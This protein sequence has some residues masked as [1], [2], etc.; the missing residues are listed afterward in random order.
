MLHPCICGETNCR[1]HVS[2]DDLCDLGVDCKIDQDVVW[3]QISMDN[4]VVV[5]V[6]Q[7]V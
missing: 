7:A 5:Q 2:D 4:V 6:Q 3:F 1:P